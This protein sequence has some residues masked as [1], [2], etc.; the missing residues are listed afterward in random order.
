MAP[1]PPFRLTLIEILILIVIAATLATIAIPRIM[2][3]RHPPA[4]APAETQT[5]APGG[6]RDTVR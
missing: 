3:R 4:A 2:S 1:R 5:R 6:A